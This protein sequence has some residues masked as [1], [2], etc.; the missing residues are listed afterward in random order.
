MW[1]S[2]GQIYGQSI[3]QSISIRI[4]RILK[5]PTRKVRFALLWHLHAEKPWKPLWAAFVFGKVSCFPKANGQIFLDVDRCGHTWNAFDESSGIHKHLNPWQAQTVIH[6]SHSRKTQK[7][8][9]KGSSMPG[10]FSCCVISF[11]TVSFLLAILRNFVYRIDM[12]G[13]FG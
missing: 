12:S 1:L 11:D 7:S 5:L 2:N 3:R 4:F 8:P 6:H 10:V 13:A 9:G